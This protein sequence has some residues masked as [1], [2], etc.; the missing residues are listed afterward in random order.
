M[1]DQFDQLWFFTNFTTPI[2]A[3]LAL[4][5]FKLLVAPPPEPLKLSPISI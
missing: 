4:E 3:Y 5:V 2:P 1:I